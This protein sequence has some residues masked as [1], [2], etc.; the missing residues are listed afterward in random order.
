MLNQARQILL[1]E[2]IYVLNIDGE[3]ATKMLDE[4]FSQR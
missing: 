4:V 3:K 2:I 1:S